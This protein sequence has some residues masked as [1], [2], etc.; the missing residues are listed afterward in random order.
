M[1][2]TVEERNLR[3]SIELTHKQV[4]QLLARHGVKTKR[5][6]TGKL[7]VLDRSTYNNKL[8]LVWIDAPMTRNSINCFD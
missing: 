5:D 1:G 2:W 6:N 3:N 4:S 8:I 7:L